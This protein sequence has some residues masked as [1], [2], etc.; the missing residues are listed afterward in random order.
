MTRDP[1]SDPQPGDEM[2][3]ATGEVRRVI[4]RDADR[5][6]CEYGVMRHSV[7]LR[8]WMVWCEKNHAMPLARDQK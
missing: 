5:L 7:T 3:S 8:R 4:R 2:V 1:R 6:L